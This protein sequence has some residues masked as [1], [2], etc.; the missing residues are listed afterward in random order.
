[1]RIVNLFKEK[2]VNPRSFR[3]LPHVKAW[4]YTRLRATVVLLCKTCDRYDLRSLR[5]I[6]MTAHNRHK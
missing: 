4:L 1:M 2:K 3:A 6:L 5:L